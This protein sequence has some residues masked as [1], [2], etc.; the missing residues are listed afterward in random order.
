M[1][2][3]GFGADG[4]Q[5]PHLAE[6]RSAPPDLSILLVA[7]N[8]G[9]CIGQCLSAIEQGC[10]RYSY[11]ILLVDN[12]AGETEELVRRSFPSTR[13]IPSRGNIG[14]AAA[15]NLLAQSASAPFLLLLN[16]DVFV[17]EGSIDR[18][19]DGAR[20]HPKA[21]AWGGVTVDIAGNPDT[22]NAIPVPSLS[23]FASAAFG[24]SRA[25]SQRDA[26]SDGDTE[27]QVTSGG[28][29]LIE[30]TA[31]EAVGGF[32]DSFFLYCE[33][34]DLFLRLAQRCKTIHKIGDAR[35]HHAIAHGG[36]LSPRRTLYRAAGTMHFVRKH[37]HPS[38]QM[39]AAFL[40]WLGA[41]VRLI[42]GGL[43]GL[44]IK[45]YADIAK[46]YQAV[47]LK[48]WL[49][50]RGYEDGR[51]MKPTSASAIGDARRD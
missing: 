15:N 3:Q 20:R 31:F 33:E 49:W 32:D 39:A 11:E 47:A 44:F 21:A 9:D 28:Y 29:V 42:A 41:A 50:V 6:K 2:G 12:G 27:V 35:A 23:E 13:I 37:W 45:R 51:G 22:G 19:V 8:S 16:P 26:I 4:V 1:S 46:G 48:P 34:V 7:F 38:R 40:I 43:L 30:R 5:P 24:R 18:L 14:F 36:N 25:A 10:N 17:E